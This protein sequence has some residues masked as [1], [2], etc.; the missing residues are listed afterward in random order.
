MDIKNTQKADRIYQ[1]LVVDD[2]PLVR[3]GLSSLI[4]SEPDLDICGETGMIS[5][6]L[7]LVRSTRP[8]LIIID[9]SLAD[10]NGLDLVKR[11]RVHDDDIRILV[12]SMHDE[13]LFAQ[14]AISAGARGYINKQEATTH[15]INAIRHVLSDKVWLSQQMT[16]RL[17]QGMVENHSEP[18]VA[19]I[20]SLSDREL[21][22]F[23]LIG[24]GMGPTQ[25]AEQLHLSVKTIETHREKIKKKLN[26]RSGSEL[27]RWAIQWIIDQE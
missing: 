17:L 7:E 20:D 26:L 21:E 5:E 15:I 19:T 6:A 24:R 23:G 1:I 16:E 9:L 25:I 8:D 11:L 10:G 4:D 13:S 14:R 12:C 2:H 3:F 22:V 27:S 18:K